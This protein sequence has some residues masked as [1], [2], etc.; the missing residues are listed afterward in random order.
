MSGTAHCQPGKGA[1]V[2]PEGARTS[3]LPS[4][5]GHDPS[6]ALHNADDDLL[7]VNDALDPRHKAQRRL[8]TFIPGVHPPEG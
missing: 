4:P 6:Q 2:E 3:D 1:S 5:V 7:N 8:A